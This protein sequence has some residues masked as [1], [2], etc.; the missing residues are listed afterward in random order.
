MLRRSREEKAKTRKGA[1][2]AKREKG[3]T[4]VKGMIVT[5]NKTL[6]RRFKWQEDKGGGKKGK[7]AEWRCAQRN[8]P[9]APPKMVV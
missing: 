8:G 5:P 2:Q 7:G 1:S 9:G 3:R 4:G 6:W